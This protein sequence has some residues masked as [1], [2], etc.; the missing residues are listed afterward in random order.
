MLRFVIGDIIMF[1]DNSVANAPEYFTSTSKLE[2]YKAGKPVLSALMIILFFIL[3]LILI[4]ALF[5]IMKVASGTDLLEL[6]AG[7]S[8][9]YEDLDAFT[10]PGVVLT[11]SYAIGS[12]SYME[13]APVH[14]NVAMPCAYCYNFA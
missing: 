1:M 14:D 3:F 9:N 10:A 7:F 11:L 13:M 8:S 5:F 12:D 4:F 6:I 2:G